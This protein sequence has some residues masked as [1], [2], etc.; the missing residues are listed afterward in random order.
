MVSV[1]VGHATDGQYDSFIQITY[2]SA[3]ILN[4]GRSKLK[5][6]NMEIRLMIIFFF[7]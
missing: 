4:Y 2:V 7:C 3:H 5:R 1:I 6:G